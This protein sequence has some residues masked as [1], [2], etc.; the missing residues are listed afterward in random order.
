M[1]DQISGDEMKI[2][3]VAKPVLIAGNFDFLG[4]S[5]DHQ[6]KQAAKDA[7]DKYGCGSC[8]PRGFYG[9]IDQHLLLEQAIADF[10]GT[11]VI[12]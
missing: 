6:I 8:G 10:M 7:L 1:I 2:R 5:R 12:I 3:G 9:T 11:E 4:F